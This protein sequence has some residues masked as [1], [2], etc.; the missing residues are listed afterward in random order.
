MLCTRV[1]RHANSC[2]AHALCC[3]AHVLH[4]TQAL[5]LRTC[6]VVPRIAHSK[7]CGGQRVK[8][9]DVPCSVHSTCCCAV[10][11][12]LEALWWTESGDGYVIATS[13]VGVPC[14]AH[15]KP[16][17]RQRMETFHMLASQPLRILVFEPLS[18]SSSQ[19]LIFR[20][21]YMVSLSSRPAKQQLAHAR[22]IFRCRAYT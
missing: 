15:S 11:C 13:H 20:T 5:A 8:D 10:C 19:R 3:G 17:G 21:C 4:N 22:S 12:P 2:F 14:I 9:V 1:T 16:C 6:G 7:L 18:S